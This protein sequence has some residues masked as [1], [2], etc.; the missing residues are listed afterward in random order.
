MVCY[1]KGVWK[2][3]GIVS[4]GYGCAQAYTPGVYTNVAHYRQWVDSVISYY[5]SHKKRGLELT[6]AHYL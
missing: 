4:W 3:A 6:G 1:R 5:T 2:V